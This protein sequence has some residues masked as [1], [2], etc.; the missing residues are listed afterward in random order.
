MKRS[1]YVVEISVQPRRVFRGD[2]LAVGSKADVKK[3]IEGE[4]VKAEAI[5][6]HIATELIPYD[7]I[8]VVW[9][10]QRGKLAAGVDVRKFIT[11]TVDDKPPVRV[12]DLKRLARYRKGVADDARTRF[13]IDWKAIEKKLPA[14]TGRRLARHERAEITLVPRIIERT[15]GKRK[16]FLTKLDGV[17]PWGYSEHQWGSG[18]PIPPFFEEFEGDPPAGRG[19]VSDR[20]GRPPAV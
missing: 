9:T 19:G 11:L 4:F 3:V 6:P 10:V 20:E 15:I 5:F 13:D 7:Q 12:D 14:L 8:V 1:F 2:L 18:P 17:V 16:S